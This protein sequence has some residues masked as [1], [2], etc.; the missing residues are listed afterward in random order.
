MSKLQNRVEKLEDQFTPSGLPLYLI[1]F[2]DGTCKALGVRYR[3]EAEARA[4]NP[5]INGSLCVTILSNVTRC[6]GEVIEYYGE[7]PSAA[8]E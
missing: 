8:I 4:A 3:S 6:P 2:P 1:V 5:A 7:G